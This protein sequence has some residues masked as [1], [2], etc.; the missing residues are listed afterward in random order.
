MRCTAVYKKV[1]YDP[2]RDGIDAYHA[3][4][5][6][7]RLLNKKVDDNNLGDVLTIPLELEK[8]V[9]DLRYIFQPQRNLVIPESAKQRLSTVPQIAFYPVVFKKLFFAPYRTGD[10]SLGPE[11][12]Y[13]L[14]P[15]LDSFRHEE[16]LRQEIENFYE[17]ILPAHD[18]L[19]KEFNNL[20]VIEFNLQTWR[21]ARLTLSE[22][23]FR[24]YP[25]IWSAEGIVFRQDIFEMIEEFF[26]W[27]YFHKG[28]L[29][30]VP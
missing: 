29:E 7:G 3:E 4:L 15:W 28:Q 10:L 12:Y 25:A 21:A 22:E 2:L 20:R 14:E 18:R 16:G 13:D 1:S 24:T 27:D 30:V 19:T 17:L 5:F 6:H 8:D 11:S 26:S 23:M 9:F